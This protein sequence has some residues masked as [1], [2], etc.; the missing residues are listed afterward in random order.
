MVIVYRI[1]FTTLFISIYSW[2]FARLHFHN[3]ELTMGQEILNGPNLASKIFIQIYIAMADIQWR[4]N[5]LIEAI[6]IYQRI[7]GHNKPP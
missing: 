1:T 7:Y 6:F 2:I 3:H 5:N 4:Q